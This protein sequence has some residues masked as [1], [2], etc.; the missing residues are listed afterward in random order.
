ML[1]WNGNESRQLR[2]SINKALQPLKLSLP[3]R[4]MA[5]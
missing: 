4:Q 3:L 5:A 1:G 2:T